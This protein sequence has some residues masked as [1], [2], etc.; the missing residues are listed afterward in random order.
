MIP[1]RDLIRKVSP[2]W[3]RTGL[4]EKILYVAGVHADLLGD[5]TRAAIRKRYPIVIESEDAFRLIGRDRKILRGIDEPPSSYAPRLRAWRASHQTR[6]GPYAL[7]EQLAAYFAHAANAPHTARLVYASGRVVEEAGRSDIVF[8]PPGGAAQC[9]RWWLML[10]YTSL[11]ATAD[12]L[13]SDPGV[14]DDGGVWDSDLASEDVEHLRAVP[15][16]WNTAHAYP[17]TP[18]GPPPIMVSMA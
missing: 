7:L 5:A 9:A 6:G 17:G 10:H 18:G 16:A 15:K 11:P 12:G 3:L 4:A 1:F 2:W 13:W 8:T 14:W